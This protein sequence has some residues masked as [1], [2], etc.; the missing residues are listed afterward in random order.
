MKVVIVSGKRGEGKTSFLKKCV[1]AL[2]QRNR[3]LFGFYAENIKTPAGSEGYLITKVN[4]GESLLLCQRDNPISGNLHLA[5]FWFDERAIKAGEQWLQEGFGT[6]KPFFI[7]DEAGKFELDGHV[8]DNSIKHLLQLETGT[9]V[10]TVRDRF[11]KRVMEKYQLDK[12]NCLVI[13]D[14]LFTVELVDE[15]ER[16]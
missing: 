14:L 6:E 3:A 2:Q 1:E 9:L 15:I 10:M 4:T 7:L 5:D 13:N 16:G 12:T 11:L 8:W